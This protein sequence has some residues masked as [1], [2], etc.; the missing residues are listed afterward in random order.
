MLRKLSAPN[1]NAPD[2]QYEDSNARAINLET[3]LVRNIIPANSHSNQENN[4]FRDPN[5]HID[6]LA[7]YEDDESS[8]DES[9]LNICITFADNAEDLEQQRLI[10]L[11]AAAA[12]FI[13]TPP[14]EDQKNF[15]TVAI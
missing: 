14:M 10:G 15:T 11:G 12:I 1:A 6:D 8:T 7:P 2:L 5:G 9:S 3:V 13:L 4:N